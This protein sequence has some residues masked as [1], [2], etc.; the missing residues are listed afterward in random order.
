MIAIYIKM[1]V[2]RYIAFMPLIIAFAAC[3]GTESDS[4]EDDVLVRVGAS[5]LTADDLAS[6]IPYGLSRDD[7]VKFTRAY[8]RTWIDNKLVG[9]IAARNISDTKRIEKLVEDY[10][11][12]LLMWEY[13]RQMY[14]EHAAESIPVDTLRAFYEAN[15][16]DFKLKSPLV[17]GIYIKVPKDAAGLSDVRKWYRSDKAADIDNL[18]KYGL[19]EAIHYDYFRDRWIAWEEV[20]AKIPFDFG[21]SPDAFLSRNKT[22]ETT[23]DGYVYLLSVSEYMPSGSVSPFEAAAESIRELLINRTR[24]DYDRELRQQLYDEGLKDGDIEV[25]V[26]LGLNDAKQ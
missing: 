3:S 16:S 22:F 13:R 1:N 24:V 26:D 4:V 9:E 17:K 7:S 8:I 18:E 11:N 5:T 2:I 23:R 19:S 14:A 12:E 15:K 25:R 21:G 6:N 10:R 20:E